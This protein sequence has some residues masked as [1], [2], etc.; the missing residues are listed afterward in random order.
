MVV[1]ARVHPI[2]VLSD[3]KSETASSI[4]TYRRLWLTHYRPVVSYD[5]EQTLNTL[6]T[7]GNVHAN[8]L[9]SGNFR[10]RDSWTLYLGDYI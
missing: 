4:I 1:I 6:P 9:H 3:D 10:A 7:S 8:F 5:T 2:D